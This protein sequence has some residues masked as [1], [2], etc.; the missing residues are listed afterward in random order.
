MRVTTWLA[1]T[2]MIARRRATPAEVE[3]FGFELASHRSP[4]ERPGSMC[5][6][7]LQMGK[8]RNVE[9][10]AA[11]IDSLVI[12]PG[13]TFSYHRTVGRPSRRRGFA[14][15]LELHD[16]ELSSGVG[17]GLCQ[18]SNMLYL[19]AVKAGLTIVERHRHSY[20]LFPDQQRTVPFG[21]GAT[22]FYN[23]RDLRFANPHPYPLV[24]RLEIDGGTLTGGLWGTSDPGHRVVMYERDHRFFREG[25]HWMRENWIRRRIVGGEGRV[26]RDEEVS[27][28]LAQVMYEP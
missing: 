16:G 17:G 13:Q 19:L 10:G 15:G 12:D 4:L 20:D 9:L 1:P 24:I 28:N 23:Y 7:T 3:R 25:D 11:L 5:S 26:L 18:V 21:C 27:H 14:L 22:V 6:T 2:D 8:E